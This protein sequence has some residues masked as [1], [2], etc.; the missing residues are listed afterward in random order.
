MSQQDNHPE[1][2]QEEQNDD[3]TTTEEQSTGDTQVEETTGD[4]SDEVARLKET[5][6]NK[7]AQIRRLSRK[8]TETSDQPNTSNSNQELEQ[9]IERLELK[10]EGYSEEVVSQIMDLGGRNSLDNPIVK[11]A[12]D[13]LVQQERVDQASNVDGTIQSSTKTN[14]SREELKTMSVA[15]ME[16]VLPKV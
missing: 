2:A 9:K 3:V 6:A 4:S 11:K 12:V 14:V 15:E 8:E 7:E 13:T 10:Q 16:K 5:L 1:V